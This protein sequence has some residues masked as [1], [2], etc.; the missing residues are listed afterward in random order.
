M[1]NLARVRTTWTGGAVSGPGV[2]TFFVDEAASGF[3]TAFDVFWDSLKYVLVAGLSLQTLNSGELIDVA[4]GGITGTWTDGV[5]SNISTSGT[6]GYALGVGARIVWSTT[7][8]T[9][10]RIVKGSTFMVPLTAA[11]YD[12]DGTIVPA[13][14]G[15]ITGAA[16]TLATA[17]GS[18]FKIYSRPIPGR[19]GSAHSV[20]SSAVPDKVSWLRSRRT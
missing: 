7:G 8:I 1:A 5:T 9:G 16:A 6:G 11:Q 10:S 18:D 14:L 3:L 2:S 19:A 15:T 20:V 12:G 17:L 13:T 4:T